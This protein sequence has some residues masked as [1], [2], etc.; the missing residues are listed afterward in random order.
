ML[1]YISATGRHFPHPVHSKAAEREVTCAQDSTKKMF[2]TDSREMCWMVSLARHHLRTSNVACQPAAFL[3]SSPATQSLFEL[4]YVSEGTSYSLG[5]G[6]QELAWFP[7]LSLLLG[8]LQINH[9]YV[10]CLFSNWNS[11]PDFLCKLLRLN[12]LQN[13]IDSL[14][15]PVHEDSNQCIA[16]AFLLLAMALTQWH[17]IPEALLSPL[18]SLWLWLTIAFSPSFC[19]FKASLS[20]WSFSR[21]LWHDDT[22]VW[23]V[24]SLETQRHEE[25]S[26][27]LLISL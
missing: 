12:K 14:N 9:S 4:P 15:T 11:S 21:D 1:C 6:M 25:K 18:V 20:T 23:Q 27:T 19:F 3:Q 22:G 2:P 26:K 8:W 7:G 24:T 13:V 16:K 5:Q 17:E 10:S